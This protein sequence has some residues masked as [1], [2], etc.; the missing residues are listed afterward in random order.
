MRW[1]LFGDCWEK[2]DELGLVNMGK[3]ASQLAFHFSAGCLKV[4]MS[5]NAVEVREEEKERSWNGHFLREK[6]QAGILGPWVGREGT[7]HILRL[8]QGHCSM[9][10]SP[11]PLP[12][13]SS[14]PK[15]L[16]ASFL[17][18]LWR[19]GGWCGEWWDLCLWVPCL[20]ELFTQPAL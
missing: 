5:E 11:S 18:F 19:R 9:P 16:P 12:H 7:L 2:R 14:W 10:T 1:A 4:G 3:R 8:N 17:N 6:S 13:P 15:C 20:G